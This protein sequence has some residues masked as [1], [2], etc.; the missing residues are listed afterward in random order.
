MDHT[1]DI[2]LGGRAILALY[3]GSGKGSPTWHQRTLLLLLLGDH[4]GRRSRGGSSG[5]QGSGA[6]RRSLDHIIGLDRRSE[7]GVGSDGT[8][9]GRDDG[10]RRRLHLTQQV[11]PRL[12]LQFGRIVHNRR[13]HL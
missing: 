1:V 3:E 8:G 10:A 13:Q 4:L 12:W 2:E 11:I 7:G 6:R 5:G 9:S